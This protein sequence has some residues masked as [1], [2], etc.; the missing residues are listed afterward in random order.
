MSTLHIGP[1][2]GAGIAETNEDGTETETEY[3]PVWEK[4]EK[5]LG[6]AEGLA[7]FIHDT[8]KDYADEEFIVPPV[9]A[10]NPEIMRGLSYAAACLVSDPHATY[11]DDEIEEKLRSILDLAILVQPEGIPSRSS[12]IALIGVSKAE[13]LVKH[14]SG[15]NCVKQIVK[16]KNKRVEEFT[17][18]VE[19]CKRIAKSPFVYAAV[20]YSSMCF[21]NALVH[22]WLLD[23]KHDIVFVED[24]RSR[25]ITSYGYMAMASAAAAGMLY[26]FD[27]DETVKTPHMKIPG[28][29]TSRSEAIER[30]KDLQ[31][32]RSVSFDV[33][34]AK[35]ERI[36]Q[37]NTHP[38]Q[39]I[40]T[41]KLKPSSGI[42]LDPV[43]IG[44]G[45]V[46]ELDT[47][48]EWMRTNRYGDRDSPHDKIMHVYTIR[49]MD[50]VKKYCD[51]ERAKIIKELDEKLARLNRAAAAEINARD[52]PD[53]R[54]QN[55]VI[56]QL[57]RQDRSP[58]H[59]PRGRPGTHA[60][61]R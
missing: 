45:C 29:I 13:K 17:K 8:V 7:S 12:G 58:S 59:L 52:N 35:N 54:Q 2:F 3:E 14:A 11:V 33:E 39:R 57:L 9:Y 40:Y 50:D 56:E 49:R 21:S 6:D 47:I 41:C 30:L 44:D 31:K 23:K 4:R 55:G 46:Y 36:S 16:F 20:C 10:S 61:G 25:E 26:F 24:E 60:F 34:E 38:I 1:T 48:L 28:L 18:N 19:L 51:E 27:D 32:T 5:L 53:P 37:Q 22:R 43:S 15:L 42:M